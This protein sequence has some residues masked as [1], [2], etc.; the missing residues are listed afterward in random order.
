MAADRSPQDFK[1]YDNEIETDTD[2][3]GSWVNFE[4]DPASGEVRVTAESADAGVAVW[5]S[6]SGVR[7]L[8]DFLSDGEA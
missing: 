5:L 8:R 3:R 7:Q 1:P 6:P 2:A 4:R